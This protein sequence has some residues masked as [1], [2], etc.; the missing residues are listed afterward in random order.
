MKNFNFRSLRTILIA[1]FSL[2]IGATLYV[3]YFGTSQKTVFQTD[4]I[5][6]VNALI[7]YNPDPIYDFDLQI[8]KRFAKGLLTNNIE[9]SIITAHHAPL[10][11]RDYDLIVFCANTYN[12]APDWGIQKVIKNQDLKNK[13]VANICLGAGSTALAEKK[14][15]KLVR[16]KEALLLG[17][18]SFWLAKP[19]GESIADKSNIEIA[20]D[21]AEKWA[22]DISDEVF[23]LEKNKSI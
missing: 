20:K 16:D 2:W 9:S 8:C 5:S 3:Q 11:L 4:D 21:H 19:N 6:Y 18:H 14:L 12:F 22:S 1:F 17:S 13:Y 7:I 10:N 15:N 23:I